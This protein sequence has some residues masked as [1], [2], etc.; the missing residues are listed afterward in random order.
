MNKMIGKKNSNGTW[1]LD[2]RGGGDI[3]VLDPYESDQ[4]VWW[5]EYSMGQ[6]SGASFFLSPRGRKRDG[7]YST[8]PSG[9]L[10][11]RLST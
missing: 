7:T 4:K 1:F 10:L 8:N 11:L 2:I 9:L 6:I 3:R 5:S